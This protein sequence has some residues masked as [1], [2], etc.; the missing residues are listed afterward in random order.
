MTKF[1]RF[2]DLRERG[3]VGNRVTLGNWIKDQGFP[4]GRL[5]GPNTRLWREDEI[6]EWLDSRPTHLKS[7]VEAVNA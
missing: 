2:D 1:L 3:I 4:T 6:E 5:V 7:A